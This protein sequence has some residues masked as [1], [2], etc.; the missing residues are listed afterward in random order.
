MKDEQKF[1]SK[2]FMRKISLY[3]LK[4]TAERSL[5]TETD[6]FKAFELQVTQNSPYVFLNRSTVVF[7]YVDDLTKVSAS[8][9]DI[10]QIKTKLCKQFVLKDPVH[11]PKFLEVEL[12]WID[13][14]TVEIS[15]TTLIELFLSREWNIQNLRVAR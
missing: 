3:G 10:T 7:C 2:L 14:R 5:Q 11:T 9:N 6:R 4:D 13:D 1:E 15:Q 12:L 8:Q